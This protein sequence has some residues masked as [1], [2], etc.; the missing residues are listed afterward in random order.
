MVF[1]AYS[2]VKL[3]LCRSKLSGKANA[4]SIGQGCRLA[5][6]EIL[7]K[8]VYWVCGCAKEIP[9]SKILDLILM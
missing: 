3:K 1:L 7:E 8:F 9:V 4:A 2:L 6:R 5:T